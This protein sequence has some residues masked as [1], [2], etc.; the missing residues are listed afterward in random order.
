MARKAEQ[1]SPYTG[2]DLTKPVD[3]QSIR[4]GISQDSC[5]GREWDMRSR[6]CPVCAMNDICGILFQD[7]VN[8]K[9]KEVEEKNVT[10]LD[11]T[12]FKSIDADAL[13]ARCVAQSGQ[14]PIEQLAEEV[15]SM[16]NTADDVAVFEWVKRFKAERN[17]KFRGGLVWKE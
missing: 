4:Q 9:V 10:F 17:L 5:L 8:V 1:I 16:A 3:K 14:L 12:D 6:E 2:V 11:K 13:Y 7:N 15:K